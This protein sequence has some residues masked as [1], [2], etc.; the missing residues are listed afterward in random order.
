[1]IEELIFEYL[2]EE[3]SC[4]WFPTRPEDDPAK[5]YGIFTKTNSIKSE[6]HLTVSTF[7][8]QTYGSTLL[9]AAQ[10]SAEL[11]KL[12]EELPLETTEV[13]KAQLSGESDFTNPADKQPRYQAIYQLVHFDD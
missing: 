2:D 7:A 4:S 12:I 6:G 10:T 3:A 9:E 1:M 11:R 13:S 5:P 8:F